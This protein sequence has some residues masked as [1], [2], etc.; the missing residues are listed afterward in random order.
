VFEDTGLGGGGV[1]W[2]D[3]V[4]IESDHSVTDDS[5]DWTLF[6]PFSSSFPDLFYRIIA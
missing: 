3:S 2:F 4:L 5:D 6:D 1:S